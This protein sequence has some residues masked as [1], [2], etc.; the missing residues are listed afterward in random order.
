MFKVATHVQ[1]EYTEEGS[2]SEMVT[3]YSKSE[4]SNRS[5]VCFWCYTGTVN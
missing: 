5:Q 4:L 1:P 3:L 2:T